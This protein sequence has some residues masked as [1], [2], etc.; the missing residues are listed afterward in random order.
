MYLQTE[1]AGSMDPQAREVRTP[2]GFAADRFEPENV[3]GVGLPDLH[4]EVSQTLDPS[5]L[6]S[7]AV[8]PA[9]AGVGTQVPY[10]QRNGRIMKA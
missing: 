2:R 10:P 5:V 7:R 6:W 3:R 4:L 1:I 8:T 9:L